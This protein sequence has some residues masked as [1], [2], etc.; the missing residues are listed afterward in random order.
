[1]KSDA[2]RE[3]CRLDPSY[4]SGNHFDF[5]NPLHRS[6]CSVFVVPTSDTRLFPDQRDEEATVLINL[7]FSD[8]VHKSWS[9][10]IPSTYIYKYRYK[11]TDKKA[12]EAFGS[13][14]D[15]L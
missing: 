14:F 15:D 9:G 7:P 11:L 6:A 10:K 8:F 2:I 13:F 5:N 3:D 12:R 4:S 1:L